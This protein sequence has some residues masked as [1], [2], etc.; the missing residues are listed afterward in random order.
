MMTSNVGLRGATRLLSA[1]AACALALPA[2]AQDAAPS[3]TLELQL[4]RS[5]LTG[6]QP[7]ARNTGLSGTW[8]FGDGQVARLDLLDETRFGLRGG[9]AALAYTR[10]LGP[11]TYLIGTL[12]L[13]HG[14]PPWARQRVDI[15]LAHK[16]GAARQ[17]VTHL[18][19]NGARFDADRSDHGLRVAGVVYFQAPLVLEG[20]VMFN[21]SHPGSVHS[22]MPYAS[23]TWGR[24]AEQTFSLRISS[25]SEAYQALGN[26]AQLV[27]FHSSSLGLTWRRW[28]D[29]AWGVVA[30]A[31]TYRNPSY[32]RHSAGAGL[33]LRF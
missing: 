11:D 9:V 23:A 5:Q 24:V 26:S 18:A 10:D 3:R 8:S 17:V 1:L 7:D 13:G 33:M 27:D 4:G 25:G 32:R 15:N 19:L 20:G 30:T 12:A 31:E 2:Q 28:L 21:V 6:G 29:P 14:G 22:R 16:W